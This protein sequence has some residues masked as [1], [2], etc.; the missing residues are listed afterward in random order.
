MSRVEGKKKPE[1]TQKIQRQKLKNPST[2]LQNDRHVARV[3]K[4]DRVYLLGA[5]PV[6]GGDGKVDAEAL[7]VDD[8]Q[9]DDDGREQVGDVGQR[10]AV[11]G[12][13]EGLDLVP[14][15]QQQVEERDNGTFEL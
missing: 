5:A 14:T 7:E 13:F 2:H 10:R 12:F 15:G 4:L 11:E 8:D 9:E 1:K 3:E 6:L